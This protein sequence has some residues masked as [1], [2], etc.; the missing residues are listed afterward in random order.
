MICREN[1]GNGGPGGV[2]SFLCALKWKPY[3]L[4]TLTQLMDVMDVRDA[5]VRIEW[6]R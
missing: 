5:L 1:S 4:G 3:E 2:P 6:G